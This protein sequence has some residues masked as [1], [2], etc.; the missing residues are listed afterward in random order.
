MQ[1]PR[2]GF[3][4]DVGAAASDAVEEAHHEGGGAAAQLFPEE[5]AFKSSVFLRK[6]GIV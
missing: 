6:T 5:K 2:C 3:R 1:S 4:H